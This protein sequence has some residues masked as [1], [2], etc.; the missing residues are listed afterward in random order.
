[1]INFL[2][3]GKS[4]LAAQAAELLGL[5]YKK[6]DMTNYSTNGSNLNLIGFE[7][8]WRDSSPGTLTTFVRDNPHC[9]LVFDE[10]EAAHEKT[11]N[12][13]CSLLEDGIITD[14]F[15]ETRNQ[16]TVIGGGQTAVNTVIRLTSSVFEIESY[17]AELGGTVKNVYERYHN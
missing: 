2:A 6:F 15:L 17:S 13:F 3:M 7:Y 8:T 9:I 4:F 12:I 11:I 14:N 16:L 5:P 1:M 10:I